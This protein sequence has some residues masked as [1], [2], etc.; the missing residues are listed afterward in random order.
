VVGRLSPMTIAFAILA[1]F[2]LE[3]ELWFRSVTRN[4]VAGGSRHR[5]R[6]VGFGFSKAKEQSIGKLELLNL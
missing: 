1:Y 6:Q 5:Q 2:G 3:V 4:E